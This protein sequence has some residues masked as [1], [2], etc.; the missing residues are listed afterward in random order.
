MTGPSVSAAGSRS[1]SESPATAG[2]A[3]GFLGW[4]KYRGRAFGLVFG[5]AVL[6]TAGASGVPPTTPTG[7]AELLGSGVGGTVEV[8]DF[9]WEPSR[10]WLADAFIGRRVVFLAR[11]RSSAARELYRGLVTVTPEGR[12][13]ALRA[14][15]PLTETDLANEE[16]LVVSSGR[17]AVRLDALAGD[18]T[19][20][21]ELLDLDGADAA[22]RASL[23]VALLRDAL[24]PLAPDTLA[25]AVSSRRL[26][27]EK[28]QRAPSFELQGGDLVVALDGGGSALVDRSGALVYAGDASIGPFVM[29]VSRR[30]AAEPPWIRALGWARGLVGEA[31]I[32]AMG[33]REPNRVSDR[34]TPGGAIDLR[35]PPD[36][37]WKAIAGHPG[38]WEVPAPSGVVMVAL[39]TRRLEFEL[40][41]GRGAARS[42]TGHA[43]SGRRRG[44]K[45]LDALVHVPIAD[46]SGAWDRGALIAP[47]R[48]DRDTLAETERGWGFGGLPDGVDA[49]SFAVQWAPEIDDAERER[50]ALCVT[51][52]G[53][54]VLAYGRST[55]SVMSAATAALDCAYATPAGA[56]SKGGVGGAFLDA[57]GEATA[58]SGASVFVEDVGNGAGGSYLAVTRLVT[59]PTARAPDDAPWVAAE[60]QPEPAAIPAIYRTTVQ[61][62]GAEV[63]V[64]LFLAN[65]FDWAI[66]AGDEEKQHRFG[67]AFE[68]ALEAPD[69]ERVYFATGLGVGKRQDPSGLKIAG[70]TGHAFHAGAGLLGVHERGLTIGLSS[71]DPTTDATEAAIAAREGSLTDDARQSGPRQSRADICALPDGSVLVA[72][73]VFDNH[74]AT[75]STLVDLGCS[76]V[77]SLDRGADRAAWARDRGDADLVG[78]RATTVLFALARPYPGTLLR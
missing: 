30:P 65:R 60:Q 4:A 22:Q 47:L 32:P 76:F 29:E 7:I 73:A 15:V 57:R 77:V 2:D 39:D 17:V 62:L 23:P 43:A 53:H 34:T 14:S 28:P 20:A 38:Y 70:V 49:P 67:G 54:L 31:P 11:R 63:T 26:V 21:I 48:A 72:D 1:P 41:P 74:E 42:R 66:R 6:A 9:V 44:S 51:R 5:C 64:R 75:A 46:G 3:V 36:D 13:L 37:R 12:P 69:V 78:E 25:S 58:W 27:F 55:A 61:T 50:S 56:P 8:Q 40:V 16:A 10:G 19:Q 24:A 18:T 33:A 52:A 45:P 35:F 68:R 59:D 71:A